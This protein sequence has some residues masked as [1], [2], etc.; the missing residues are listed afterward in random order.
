MDEKHKLY[1]MT[2][3]TVWVKENNLTQ[4][5]ASKTLRISRPRVSD[6]VNNKTSKFTVDTLITLLLRAGKT[7]TIEVENEN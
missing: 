3:L 4:A 1:L 7:I 6:L 5:Q 2:Q